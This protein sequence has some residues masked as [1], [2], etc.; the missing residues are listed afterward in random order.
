[1]LFC[2]VF[3]RLRGQNSSAEAGKLFLQRK[4]EIT[5]TSNLRPVTH[6]PATPAVTGAEA[7]FQ[8]RAVL[9]PEDSSL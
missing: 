9:I 5:G 1:M 3:I 8:Q 2:Q 4:W 6:S 7:V